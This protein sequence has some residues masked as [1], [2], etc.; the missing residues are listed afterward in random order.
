MFLFLPS[1][2]LLEGDH[3]VNN[4]LLDGTG[5]EHVVEGEGRRS[6]SRLNCYTAHV[7]QILEETWDVVGDVLHGVERSLA[8]LFAAQAEGGTLT[9]IMRFLVTI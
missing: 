1:S 9:S 7:H 2:H 6:A 8:T 5:V 4:F 3:A